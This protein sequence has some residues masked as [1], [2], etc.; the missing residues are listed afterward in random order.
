MIVV[1]LK[2][3][4]LLNKWQKE[5]MFG[6]MEKRKHVH[7]NFPIIG[8]SKILQ[9]V[10]QKQRNLFKTYMIYIPVVNKYVKNKENIPLVNFPQ[11]VMGLKVNWWKFSKAVKKHWTV[12]LQVALNVASALTRMAVGAKTKS[13]KDR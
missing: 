8:F 9:G 6:I 13:H 2:V 5:A 1:V 7:C 12:F 10:I 3:K 11:R 4:F